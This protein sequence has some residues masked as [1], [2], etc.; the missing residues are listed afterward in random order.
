MEMAMMMLV[1]RV[2]LQGELERVKI[3]LVLDKWFRVSHCNA[4]I[5]QERRWEQP[6]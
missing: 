1:K 2:M 6:N 4:H 5:Y 3:V